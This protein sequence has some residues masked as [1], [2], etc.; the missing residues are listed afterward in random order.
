[1]GNVMISLGDD[2]EMLLR[3]LAQ[4]MYGGKK[5][6]ISAVVLHALE[7]VAVKNKR[8]R[9]ARHQIALM[10]TGFNL[11]LKNKKVYNTRNE[12]YD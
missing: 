3:N 1:M 6:A 4:E 7:E 9:A 5:G 2:K 10:K 11:G 12:I 8:M